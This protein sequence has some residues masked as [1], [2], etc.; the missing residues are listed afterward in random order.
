M[1]VALDGGVI[2]SA[3]VKIIVVDK[4]VRYDDERDVAGEAAVVPPVG[5]LGGDAIGV[6]RVVD[7]EDG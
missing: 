6:A 5:L 1:N 3:E 4:D 2:G 7:G